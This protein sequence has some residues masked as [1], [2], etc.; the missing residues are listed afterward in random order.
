MNIIQVIVIAMFVLVV[1]CAMREMYTSIMHDYTWVQARHM[2]A[3][4]K[5]QYTLLAIRMRDMHDAQYE[6][7]M[8]MLDTTPTHEG[9]AWGTWDATPYDSASDITTSYR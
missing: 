1:V 4:N 3:R 5:A 6:Y 2:R 7:G 9:D 8:S